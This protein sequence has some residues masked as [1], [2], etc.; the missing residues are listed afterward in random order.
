[1]LTSRGGT[2]VIADLTALGYDTKWTVMGAADIGANHQRDRIWILA[3][4]TN[5]QPTFA[6]Q[7]RK[8][9]RPEKLD[10][11]CGR[12]VGA[13][14]AKEDLAHP[15]SLRQQEQRQR[16]HASDCEAYRS[17]QTSHVNHDGQWW[18]VEPNVGRVADG[19]AARVDRLKA[20]GNGQV[21]LCAAAAWHLLQEVEPS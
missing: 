18:A 11:N 16:R 4:N 12:Q 2:R 6:E 10:G 3:T 9:Q 20:I 1:M 8:H 21:P 17:W 7:K 15:S 19:V 13:F 5:L 14:D